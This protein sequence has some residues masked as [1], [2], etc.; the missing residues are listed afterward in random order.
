VANVPIF[1]LNVLATPHVAGST[2]ISMRGILAGVVENIRRLEAGQM[3]LN[4]I[5][6]R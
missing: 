1:D 5:Q 6:P 2:D 3:P 4:C